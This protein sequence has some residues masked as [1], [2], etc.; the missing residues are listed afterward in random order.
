MRF[1][2][3]DRA[4]QEE[5]VL[6]VTPASFELSHGVKMETINI[7]TLGD[8]NL[9]GYGTMPSFKV[10]CMFPAKCYPFNRS[11]TVIPPYD[12]VWKLEAWCDKHTVLDWYIDTLIVPVLIESISY[13]EKDGTRDVYATINMRKYRQLFAVTSERKS[14]GNSSRTGESESITTS[15]T[16]TVVPGDTLSAIARKFYGDSSLYAKL[17]KFNNI[18]NAN[19]IRSGQIINLPDKRLL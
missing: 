11:E 3:K 7:H 4:T 19:L 18:K 5:L 2:F 15:Q 9:A 6:P 1:S 8:V 14:T 16:Y 13:G 17:A 12:Y 10:D